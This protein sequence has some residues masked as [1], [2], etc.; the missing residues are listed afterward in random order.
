MK[1]HFNFIDIFKYQNKPRVQT[2]CSMR[3]M[4]P[5]VL[6]HIPIGSLRNPVKRDRKGNPKEEAMDEEN[7]YL[8]PTQSLSDSESES[9]SEFDEQS[10]HQAFME[11]VTIHLTDNAEHYDAQFR[12]VARELY[13][14]HA[15]TIIKQETALALSRAKL[16]EEKE[17]KKALLA[18]IPN[19]TNQKSPTRLAE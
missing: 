8:T 18:S 19:S 4:P 12:S 7:I 6:D 17:A 1:F 9:G 16:K 5:V 13:A 11:A 3:S 10:C 14:L 15:A 2:V